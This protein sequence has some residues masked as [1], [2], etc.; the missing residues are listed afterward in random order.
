MSL[1]IVP[2][3]FLDYYKSLGNPPR[4]PPSPTALDRIR[5]SLHKSYYQYMVTFS[6]YMLDP[7][8][9]FLFDFLLGL[10]LC[11][12]IWCSTLMTPPLGKLVLLGLKGGVF[13]SNEVKKL[14]SV[15]VEGWTGNMT[16]RVTTT[17]GTIGTGENCTAV[18]L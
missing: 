17:L 16:M 3:L 9:R 12:I 5:Y 8:E 15:V 10:M 7:T 6:G 13:D 14:G 11:A 1:T 4:L 2:L 18:G